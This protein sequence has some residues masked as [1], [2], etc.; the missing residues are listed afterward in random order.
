MNKKTVVLVA[1]ALLLASGLYIFY[2]SR[3]IN[4]KTQI[5]TTEKS[6]SPIV[7]EYYSR[8]ETV[9]GDIY[10]D[11][12][13]RYTDGRVELFAP[14][15]L[16]DD[17]LWL[18]SEYQEKQLQKENSAAA[19]RQSTPGGGGIILKPEEV[20][21][22]V[23]LEDNNEILIAINQFFSERRQQNQGESPL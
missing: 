13:G 10:F 3:E 12:V 8:V 1:I 21:S 23:K 5:T 17:T 9:N 18:F 14:F 22:I 2:K 6:E 19:I 4:P 11:A 7:E 16:V 15:I 20:K